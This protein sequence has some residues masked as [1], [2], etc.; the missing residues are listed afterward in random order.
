MDTPNKTTSPTKRPVRKNYS[1]DKADRNKERR[2]DEAEVRT[3]EYH[4]LTIA[5]RITRAKSRPGQ[6]AK[7]IARLERQL[8]DSE[9]QKAQKVTAT[10]AKAA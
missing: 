8:K 6:S 10:K 5:Q 7:E 4:S 2:R 9:W 3:D 1:H